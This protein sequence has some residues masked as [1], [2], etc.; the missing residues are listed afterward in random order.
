MNSGHS[1]IERREVWVL[2]SREL[3][4]YLEKDLDWP[5][6]QLSGW[7]RRWRKHLGQ[8]EWD[9]QTTHV[10]VSSLS[11]KKGIACTIARHLRGHWTVE[12]G[13]FRVRD[14]SY[15]EDRLHGR[16]IGLSLSALRNVAINLIRRNNYPY[17]PDA[18]RAFAARSDR[19]LDPLC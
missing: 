5:G 11:P 15:D 9:S 17:V 4:E 12:N 8:T 13:I 3:G 14:V 18:R 10:W 7:I 2:D 19:G 6:V 1:R 16:K